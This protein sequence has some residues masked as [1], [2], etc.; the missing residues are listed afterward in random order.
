MCHTKPY[1]IKSPLVIRILP[2]FVTVL[3]A[4]AEEHL[5]PVNLLQLGDA[6]TQKFHQMGT[7]TFELAQIKGP[8]L[9]HYKQDECRCHRM[10]H[11]YMMYGKP[12]VASLPVEFDER[13]WVR[14]Y[15]DFLRQHVSSLDNLGGPCLR[16]IATIAIAR[17]Q[18]E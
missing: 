1:P 16:A 10:S 15:R 3:R 8:E 12:Y 14:G 11:F 17:G 9:F 13:D 4:A 18:W 7:C 2:A 5:S 6:L